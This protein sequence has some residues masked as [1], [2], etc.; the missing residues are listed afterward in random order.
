[1]SPGRRDRNAVT[2]RSGAASPCRPVSAVCLLLALAGLPLPLAAQAPE[3]ALVSNLNKVTT[4]FSTVENGHLWAQAFVTGSESRGYRL[5]SVVLQFNNQDSIDS[6]TLRVT[7]RR[8]GGFGNYPGS[9]LSTLTNPSSVTNV[10]PNEFTAPAN[11]VLAR[12]TRYHV[13]VEYPS[14]SES[15]RWSQAGRGEDAGA[16][17][18]WDIPGRVT[19]NTGGFWTFDDDFNF[20]ME[21]R[22][23]AI[24]PDSATLSVA[25]VS[26][27]VA[28]GDDAQFTVTR[29]GVTSG[30]LTVN[31]S[32]SESGAMV[33]SG[34]EG[35]QTVDFAGS[36]TSVTVTVP[37]VDDGAHEADSAVTVALTADA[38]YE[39]GTD[40]TAE[41][42]VTD[43]DNAAPT[44]A[45]TIDDTTPV[46]G[47][48]L[49]ADASGLGDPDGLT[50]R[51]FTYQWIRT[52]GGTVTRIA[53]ETAA[54]YTVV[55]AD[56]GA[57]LKVAVS[58]TD[59]DGTAETV[60]SAETAAALAEEPLTI[61]D[62]DRDY[63]LATIYRQTATVE[64]ADYLAE[65]VSLSDV[66]FALDNC[67]DTRADYYSSVTL[68]GS[69]LS[70][71]SNDLGHTHGAATDS[72]TT[73]V[74]T[75][76]MSGESLDQTFA[77][78]IPPGRQLTQIP[79]VSVVGRSANAL[80]VRVTDPSGYGSSRLRLSWRET[81]TNAWTHRIMSGAMLDSATPP[82]IRIDGL[83]S[84]TSY[85]VQ[86]AVLRRQGL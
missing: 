72:E 47:E 80:E 60:E 38:A 81:G 9:I 34:E 67:D 28:E 6:A 49:N 36:A 16:A 11:V 50:N 73:C 18:G 78:R 41:V 25:P 10:G 52:S 57:T 82:A 1:M 20:A 45:V 83:D 27:T 74:V 14:D 35:A 77:F 66:S 29:T 2:A 62:A 8:N 13:V 68:S 64:L 48:T 85:T 69:T 53:G 23:T 86:A 17:D 46:L 37:T 42:T 30:A 31:Y 71:V 4:E 5:H 26:T 19:Y 40:D 79:V 39:L 55:A 84:E 75:A 15:P 24:V 3:P 54:S 51:S 65:G 22:G 59:D 61:F 12:G 33:A 7:V 43:D 58:F 56:V 63:S 70:L 76:T 44:G 32:V 21:V